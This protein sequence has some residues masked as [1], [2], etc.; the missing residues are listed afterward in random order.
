M[1]KKHYHSLNVKIDNNI[2]HHFLYHVTYVYI[3]SVARL[4]DVVLSG[5]D[6]ISAD[7]L[8][9]EWYYTYTSSERLLCVSRSYVCIHIL[10]M[11]EVFR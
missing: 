3:A 5:T 9:I 11:Y 7:L 1:L 8:H 2:V 10:F 6:K 4:S